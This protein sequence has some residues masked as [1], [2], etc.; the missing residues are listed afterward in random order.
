MKTL[1]VCS[2]TLALTESIFAQGS[3]TPPGA[4]APTMKSL[5]Q[6]EA[7]TPI[8]SA[9]FFINASGSYYLTKNLTVATGSA[10][11]INVSDVSLDLNGFTISSTQNP[12]SSGVAIYMTG[13]SRN[14]AIFNGAISSGVTVSGGTY[15]GTGFGYGVY[16]PSAV[17]VR[18][19][20]VSVAGVLNHGIYLGFSSSVVEACTVDTAGGYGIAASA[21]SHST[22]LNTGSAGVFGNNVSDCCCTSSLYG[23]YALTATASDVAGNT[24]TWHL[25]HHRN[26]LL[27]F[28]HF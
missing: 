24:A 23:I 1:L 3:I 28:G 8:S 11:A 2:A 16:C 9:P 21:V 6:I 10:I 17:S 20:G 22:A 14:V 19:S 18:V 26:Q 13:A 7:R 5:D 27:R 25:R 15:S 4:P 12:A